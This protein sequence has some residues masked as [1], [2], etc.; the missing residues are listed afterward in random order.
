LPND[1]PARLD[2]GSSSSSGASIT[3]LSGPGSIYLFTNPATPSEIASA[4]R[5]TELANMPQTF[6]NGSGGP[7]FNWGKFF[8][9]ISQI[10]QIADNGIKTYQAFHPPTVPYTPV[11]P[12]IPN[13][14]NV[15]KT[16]GATSK[17]PGATTTTGTTTQTPPSTG[18]QTCQ[19]VPNPAALACLAEPIMINGL[20]ND[21]DH[22]GGNPAAPFIPTM[23]LQC[24]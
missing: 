22:V 7:S 6:N 15:P 19:Y 14:L 12:P 24:N 10:A 8:D 11:H 23:I 21:C 2:D 16:P 9:T 1:S 18:V 3:S 17:P 5:A 4:N 13:A 20:P